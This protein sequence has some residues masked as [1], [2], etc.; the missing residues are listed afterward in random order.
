LKKIFENLPIQN[1]PKANQFNIQ[2]TKC[3]A[4]NQPVL[5]AIII[6]P[7]HQPM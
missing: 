7:Q 4:A 3:R 2:Y 1:N 6:L 5:D